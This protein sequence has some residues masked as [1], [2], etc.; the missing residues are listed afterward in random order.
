MR[1]IALAL[2]LLAAPAF[3]GKAKPKEGQFCKKTQ[4]GNTKTD[5][6]GATLTCKADKNGKL[7]WDK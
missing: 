3:A 7:R 6:S 4:E 1:R 5:K 2:L